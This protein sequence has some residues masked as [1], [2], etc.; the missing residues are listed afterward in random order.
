MG[1]HMHGYAAPGTNRLAHL[2]SSYRNRRMGLRTYFMPVYVIVPAIRAA[3]I[4]FLYLLSIIST[5]GSG[6]VPKSPQWFP[7]P[8]KE[9]N[10][11][12]MG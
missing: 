4:E 6:G 8:A 10:L 3:L 7:I 11:T 5:L 1:R 2:S 9:I 12:C